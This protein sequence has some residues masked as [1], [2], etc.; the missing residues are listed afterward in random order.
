MTFSNS[1]T[2]KNRTTGGGFQFGDGFVQ[3]V[4]N[5]KMYKLFELI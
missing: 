5:I 3:F 2:F 4:Y 1:I